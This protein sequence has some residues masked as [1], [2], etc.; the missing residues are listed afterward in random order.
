MT[1]ALITIGAICQLTIL[2]STKENLNTWVTVKANVK[3]DFMILHGI[4]VSDISGVAIMTD[5]DN[6]K[7]RAISYYQDIYFSAE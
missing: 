2:P 4:D 5:T 1:I 7:L 3:K 6:S